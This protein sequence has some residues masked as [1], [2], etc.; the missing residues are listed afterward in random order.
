MAKK[1]SAKKTEEQ[2][3]QVA[4][5]LRT[6]TAYSFNTETGEYVGEATVQED[7]LAPGLFLMPGGTTLIAP[8][9]PQGGKKIVFKDGAWG[10]EDIPVV[11]EV[12]ET[13][14]EKALKARGRRNAELVVSDW[15]QLP[16]VPAWVNQSAW[17]T[18]RQA[19]R[20][21]PQQAGFPNS[22]SWPQQPVR[23]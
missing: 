10:F 1:K 6:I 21:V 9:A 15:T 18:Y 23:S 19:L 4:E 14:Q 12:P 11:E 20:D 13:D 17:A 5:I 7:P 16:D 3:E 8:P 2:P 22:I